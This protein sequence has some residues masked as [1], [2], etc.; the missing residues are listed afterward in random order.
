[1]MFK[2]ILVFL[3]AVKASLERSF[4]GGMDTQCVRENQRVNEI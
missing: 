2:S 3:S 1:M 4:N